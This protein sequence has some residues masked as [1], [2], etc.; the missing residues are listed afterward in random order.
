MYSAKESGRNIFCFFDQLMNQK[1]VTKMQIERGLRDALIKKEFR[2]MYQPIVRVS[3]N[4]IR[5]FE[6]LIRWFPSEGGLIFPDEFIGVAEETGLIIPMGEWVLQE[7]CRFA[8]YLIDAGHGEC[9]VSVNLSVA[10]LRRQNILETIENALR[11]CNVPA[12]NLEIEVTESIL[13]GSFDNALDLLHKIN[14]IG[15][16][17]SLDDFG[18][19]YS[20]LSHLQRLP[21]THLKIDRLFINEIA[22]SKSGHT[23]TPAIIDLAHKLN[24]VVVAEGVET[25]EQL[26]ILSRYKCDL[27]QGYVLSKPLSQDQVLGLWNA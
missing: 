21:I 9:V 10:Q 16:R 3:D 20:S 12:M 5:E 8:R 22:N 17:I 24:L 26:A 2:L 18:T 14:N 23:L 6:A 11:E 13:I 15:V 27:Y 25:V 7:A 1:A 19:G 4:K